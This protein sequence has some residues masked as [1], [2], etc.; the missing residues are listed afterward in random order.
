M[1]Q[2]RLHLHRRGFAQWEWNRNEPHTDSSTHT[3]INQIK[4][5][6][7]QIEQS[8][9][10]CS[11]ISGAVSH[12]SIWLC[13]AFSVAGQLSRLQGKLHDYFWHF[14]LS[15][16]PPALTLKRHAEQRDRNAKNIKIALNLRNR[17]HPNMDRL[18]VRVCVIVCPSIYDDKI[19]RATT[20]KYAWALF[21]FQRKITNEQKKKQNYT[22]RR[23]PTIYAKHTSSE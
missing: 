14:T 2:L 15:H 8:Q 10:S 17:T 3:P 22:N 6:S 7:P 4:F 20:V 11:C 13:T 1:I 9:A 16:M 18:C 5:V 23:N 12:F 21:I 19:Q